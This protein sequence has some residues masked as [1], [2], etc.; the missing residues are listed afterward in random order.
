MQAPRRPRQLLLEP[1]LTAARRAGRRAPMQ[2]ALRSKDFEHAGSTNSFGDEQ[3]EVR[4]GAAAAPLQVEAAG[5]RSPWAPASPLAT[6]AR[7]S[8][9]A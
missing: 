9:P 4:A 1:G 8:M 3:L 2:D 5:S 6:R 7:L